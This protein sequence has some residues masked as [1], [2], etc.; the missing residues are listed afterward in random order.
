VELVEE[1]APDRQDCRPKV[2]ASAVEELTVDLQA[3]PVDQVPAA[4]VVLACHLCHPVD[5]VEM[6]ALDPLRESAVVWLRRPASR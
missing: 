3:F 1:S 4:S 6:Q 5:Q 2:L